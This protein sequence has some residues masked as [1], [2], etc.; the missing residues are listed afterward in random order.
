[1]AMATA[2][3]HDA[4]LL[5][6][7]MGGDITADEVKAASTTTHDATGFHTS[8]EGSTFVTLVVAGIP[9]MGTPPPNTQINLVGFGHVVLNGQITKMKP[10]SAAFTVNM[11]HASITA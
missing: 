1:Q 2:V 8:A 3:D 9:I 6:K 5:I 10:T 4:N 7:Q 11:I